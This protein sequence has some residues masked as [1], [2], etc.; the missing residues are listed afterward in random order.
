MKTIGLIGGMSWESSLE[1]YRIINEEVK[2]RLGGFHSCPSV[3]VSVDFS[4]VERLQHQG[5]WD[6]LTELLAGAALQAQRG[7]AELAV[8][9]TNTMHKLFDAVQAR[10]EIPLVHIADA[11]GQEA[12]RLG[13]NTVGLL[14]TRFTMEQGFYRER[15]EQ[16]GLKVL[17]PAAED[18]ETVHRVIYGELVMGRFTEEARQQFRE[19]I[20]RLQEAGAE[21]IVLGCTEIPLLVKPGDVPVPLLD[22]TALHARLAVAM[23]LANRSAGQEGV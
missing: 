11:A 12:L 7:G 13:L 6:G 15:L 20:G 8:I 14:G 17:I 2:S 19:I 3:M 23:A 1:Y 22:T 10:L 4:T 5:D 18:R 21:G 9:C 16:Q